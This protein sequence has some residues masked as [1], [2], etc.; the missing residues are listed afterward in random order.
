MHLRR[1]CLRAAAGLAVAALL[2]CVEFAGARI[3]VYNGSA[4][5]LT[6]IEL[7][8]TGFIETIASLAPGDVASLRVKPTGESGLSVAFV[9]DG[10]RHTIE[11]QGYFEPSGHYQVR[12]EVRNDLTV[13]VRTFLK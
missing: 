4:E 9:V 13:S 10:E 1:G 5:T 3:N 11:E 7:T 8:G 12:V 6:D 2:A